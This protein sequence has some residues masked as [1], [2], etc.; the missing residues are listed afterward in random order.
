M[1]MGQ[2]TVIDRYPFKP[3]SDITREA[4]RANRNEHKQ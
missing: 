4:E 3:A 2:M 1:S